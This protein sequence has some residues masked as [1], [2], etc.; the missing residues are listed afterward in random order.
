MFR[1]SWWWQRWETDWVV[2]DIL[3]WR[4]NERDRVSNHRRLDCLLNG[5]FRRKSKKTSKLRVT[6]LYQG[7]LPVTDSIPAQRASNAGMFPFDDVIM[8][9]TIFNDFV[10][11][12]LYNNKR[13]LMWNTAVHESSQC[14]YRCNRATAYWTLWS[15]RNWQSNYKMGLIPTPLLWCKSNNVTEIFHLLYEFQTPKLE[16]SMANVYGLFW[17]IFAYINSPPTRF[18]QYQNYRYVQKLSG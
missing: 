1:D 3:Q 7:N 13:F 15:W 9:H 12:L 8:N 5:L 2:S 11:Q 17:C 4:H 14:K 18:G 10:N 6:G 16:I